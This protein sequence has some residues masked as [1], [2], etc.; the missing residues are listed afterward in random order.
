M[1]HNLIP[2]DDMLG[3]F[4]VRV[5]HSELMREF[6][7]KRN[8]YFETNMPD[9]ETD[10]YRLDDTD[11]EQQAMEFYEKAFENAFPQLMADFRNIE[12]AYEEEEEHVIDVLVGKVQSEH[13]DLVHALISERANLRIAVLR[14][15]NK[16]YE[17]IEEK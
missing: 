17:S 10:S 15:V 16:L 8:K 5:V 7:A 2:G 6:I 4:V 1:K 13:A 14:A 3:Y 11:D 9:H 12:R